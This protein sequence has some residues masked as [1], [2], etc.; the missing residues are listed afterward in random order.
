M[1]ALP[2]AFQARATRRAGGSD[3]RSSTALRWRRPAALAPPLTPPPP[4]AQEGGWVLTVGFTLLFTALSAL[5]AAYVVKAVQFFKARQAE[6]R[7]LR[8]PEQGRASQSPARTTDG[9]GDDLL[10]LELLVRVTSTRPWWV[11]FQARARPPL[12]RAQRV[13]RPLSPPGRR[14]RPS[15]APRPSGCPHRC[16]VAAFGLL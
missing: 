13:P 2:I 1:L 7:K 8:T 5:C 10:E 3:A 15:R 9:E 16:A 11:V 6:S 4:A 12:T 14:P